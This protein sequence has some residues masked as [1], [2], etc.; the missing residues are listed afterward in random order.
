MD[1]H[2][3]ATFLSNCDVKCTTHTTDWFTMLSERVWGVYIF[4]CLSDIYSCRRWREMETSG[5]ASCIRANFIPPAPFL[6]YKSNLFLLE[7]YCGVSNAPD[8]I[9][10]IEVAIWPQAGSIEKL[11]SCADLNRCHPCVLVRNV[12]WIGKLWSIFTFSK[13]T[14]SKMSMHWDM[15]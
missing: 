7:D 9:C 10:V 11:F 6:R 4:M 5:Y 2:S 1:D 3:N 12:Y 8:L 13:V 14:L 15:Y